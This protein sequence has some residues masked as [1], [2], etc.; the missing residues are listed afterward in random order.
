MIDGALPP[1]LAIVSLSILTAYTANVLVTNIEL[2]QRVSAKKTGG[3]NQLF[4]T[5]KRSCEMLYSYKTKK[6]RRLSFY[7]YNGFCKFSSE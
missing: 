4:L 1:K 5:K 6:E 7:G 3:F 2:F